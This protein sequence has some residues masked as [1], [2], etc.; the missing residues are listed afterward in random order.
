MKT[1]K[2]TTSVKA[3]KKR[4]QLIRQSCVP[5]TLILVLGQNL[6]M[7]LLLSL[8]ETRNAKKMS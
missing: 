5:G 7:A 2:I 6:E 8:P 3:S 1:A 4:W